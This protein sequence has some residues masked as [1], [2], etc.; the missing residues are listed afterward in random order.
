MKETLLT[1]LGILL[2]SLLYGQSQTDKLNKMLGVLEK[3]KT[4]SYYSISSSSAPGDTLPFRTNEF[5]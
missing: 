4:A 1:G 2:A 5:L 3:I